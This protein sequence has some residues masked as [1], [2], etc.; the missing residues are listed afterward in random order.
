MI[1]RL[2]YPCLR[3]LMMR[4]SSMVTMRSAPSAIFFIMGDQK[5]RLFQT[6]VGQLEQIQDFC[7]IL[8]VQVTCGL[9]S[10]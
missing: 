10:Q 8:P 3:S 7:R 6:P 4:P 1:N 2:P 5:N 9:I